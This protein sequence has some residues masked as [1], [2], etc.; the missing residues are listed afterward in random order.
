MQSTESENS[1]GY[2]PA[3]ILFMYY[4]WIIFIYEALKILIENYS[5]D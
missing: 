1:T 2:N 4:N 5:S 3:I